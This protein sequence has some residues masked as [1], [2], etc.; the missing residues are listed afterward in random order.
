MNRIFCC[1]LFVLIA[2]NETAATP[3]DTVRVRLETTMGNITIALSM[4][5]RSIVIIFSVSYA[6]AI[7]MVCCSIAS[8]SVSWYKR[9]IPIPARLLPG[10]SL[11]R[12][13]LIIRFLPRYAYPLCSIVAV[14]WQLPVKAMM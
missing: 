6:T 9:A 3:A 4:K 11:V 8:S 14:P 13:A 12:V 5:R 7:M 2:V 1:L 10:R